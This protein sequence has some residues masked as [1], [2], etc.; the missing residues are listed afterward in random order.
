MRYISALPFCNAKESIFIDL[1]TAAS[2]GMLSLADVAHVQHVFQ[3]RT[4]MHMRPHDSIADGTKRIAARPGMAL[5]VVCLPP[6]FRI[7]YTRLNNCIRATVL[8]RRGVSARYGQGHVCFIA[9]GQAAPRPPIN[10]CVSANICTACIWP[11][12]PGLTGGGCAIGGRSGKS[13]E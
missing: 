4:A 3:R 12:T 8:M 5:L 9:G 1:R 11:N 10:W 7:L 6:G 2:L 13:V